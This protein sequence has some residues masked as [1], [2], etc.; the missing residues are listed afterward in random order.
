MLREGVRFELP[1]EERDVSFEVIPVK[2]PGIESR[3]FLILFSQPSVR[4]P[5]PQPAGL[6]TR[7]WRFFGAGSA[8]ETE[9]DNQIARLRRELDATRDYLQATIEEHEAA[10]EEMKSAHEEALSANEEFLS[11]NEELET[12]KEE[13]QSANEELG[14]TNQE[15][16]DRNREL[17][18]LNDE[19]RWSRNYLDAIVETLRESLL[20]LDGDLRVEKAN[21]QF[22]ETFH[23]SPEETLHRHLYDLGDGQWNIPELRRLLGNILTA[24]RPCEISRWSMT[25]PTIGEKTMLLNARRSGFR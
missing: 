22:Y 10:K 1:G 19:L 18:D 13:L 20:V 23:V 17:T 15:L 21:H 4:H 5:E 12:A 14:V 6:L 11:T 3:Y 8:V 16:R 25:F 7:L 9:K 24:N 2:L